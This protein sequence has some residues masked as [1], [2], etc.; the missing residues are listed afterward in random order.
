[1][2][3]FALCFAVVTE[4]LWALSLKW[5]SVLGNWQAAAVP[6]VLSFVNMGLL[7]L[8]MRGLPAGMTYALWTGAGTVGVVLGGALF[9]GD[10]VSTPQLFFIALI[11]IG[12]V[13]TKFFSSQA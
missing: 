1:M 9:F 4:I 6:I 7:A 11:I 5:A 13:G 8:A 3:W 10:K 2:A 12:S